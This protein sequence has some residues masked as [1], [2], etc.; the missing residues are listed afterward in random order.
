MGTVTGSE[1]YTNT[2]HLFSGFSV[3]LKVKGFYYT[4]CIH[5]EKE[6]DGRDRD[7]Q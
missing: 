1:K 5:S 4:T 2:R 3:D 7:R 6:R